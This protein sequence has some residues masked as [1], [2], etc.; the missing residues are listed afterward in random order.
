M[1]AGTMRYRLTVMRRAII[2]G[3]PGGDPRGDYA[4]A[5]TARAALKQKNAFNQ[6]EAGFVE[7]M[8]VIVLRVYA[9][10]DTNTITIADRLKIEGP[11]APPSP[12]PSV[13]WAVDS[14]NIPDA[15]R[16]HIE[17]TAISRIG[18]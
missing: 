17:I 6:A 5:F 7:N 12:S 16:R 15:G 13:D 8:N 4:P 18:G 2:P 11:N 9:N 10:T 1:L 3:N 14:V